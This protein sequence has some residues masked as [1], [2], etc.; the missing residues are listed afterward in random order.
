MK[1]IF[2]KLGILLVALFAVNT[3]SA[4]STGTSKATYFLMALGV[5]VVFYLIYFFVERVFRAKPVFAPS[6]P[7][8]AKGKEVKILTKG[9]DIKLKGEATEKLEPAKDVRTFALQ[10]PNF[11]GISPI[12]KLA[13]EQGSHVKAG[14]VIFFDKKRPAIKYVAPV[15]G[16]VIAV[17]RGARRA[18]EEVVISSDKQLDYKAFSDFDLKTSSREALVDYLLESGVWPMIIQRPFDIVPEPTD[19]PRDIFISTFDTAPL[20]PDLNFVVE[21]K[22][23]AFQKGLDVLNRLTEG[24]VYLGLNAKGKEAP[25]KVFSEAKGVDLRWFHGKHP[26]GNVGIQIHHIKPIGPKDKVW[27]LGVQ[28]VITL[29][30]LFIEKRFDAERIVA[31][32]GKEVKKPSYVKTHLGANVGELMKNRLEED[33]VRL[34]SGDV[35]SGQAKSANDFLDFHDDQLSVIEEGD[36]FEAFGWLVAGSA[37]PTATKAF[38]TSFLPKKAYKVDTNIHGEKRAFVMT[39]QYA[40]LLPMN[41]FPQ[42]LMKAIIVN[43]YEQMEGLGLHELTEEDVALCEFACTSKQSLQNILR[44]GLDMMREDS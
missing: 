43:D 39:G 3:A 1:I 40:D 15:S 34:I 2:N 44:Q 30:T 33:H 10:P 21:G 7:A 9:H 5:F 42:L 22:G 24:K 31:I 38:V 18:I 32:T 27:T 29:G 17:N 19:V 36:Y 12:P 23:K 25:S 26:A 20:A 16:E 13:V 41:I 35:L 6:I 8:F 4:Q 28:D 11:I 37:R 14:D